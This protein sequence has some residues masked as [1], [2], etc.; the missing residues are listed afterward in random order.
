MLCCVFFF[1]LA[2]PAEI[3]FQSTCRI[4]E[5]V[6]ENISVALLCSLFAAYLSCQFQPYFCRIDYRFLD[7]S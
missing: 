5:D 7:L 3:F 2:E 4:E 1:S 6:V